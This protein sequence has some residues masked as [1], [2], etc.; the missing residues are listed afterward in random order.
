MAN[1]NIMYNQT[2]KNIMYNKIPDMTTP[3]DT[4]HKETA[5]SAIQ[6]RKATY[7]KMKQEA[8]DARERTIQFHQQ[9]KE[10]D[11]LS[12]IPVADIPEGYGIN[13]FGE[14]VRPGKSR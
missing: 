7:E 13:E 3:I 1:D 11:M 2:N 10:D 8:L 5:M 6:A 4:S 14:I 9:M 12:K